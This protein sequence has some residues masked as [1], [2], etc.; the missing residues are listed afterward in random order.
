MDY[1]TESVQHQFAL[2]SF[3]SF[4]HKT[5]NRSRHQSKSQVCLHYFQA[6]M[7]NLECRLLFNKALPHFSMTNYHR[8]IALEWKA[9]FEEYE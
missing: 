5:T 2:H 9:L 7:R 8:I 4:V 6:Q 3:L 1:M